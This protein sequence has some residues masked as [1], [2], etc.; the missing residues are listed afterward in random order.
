MTIE[1]I[2]AGRAAVDVMPQPF[3]GRKVG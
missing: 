2:A 1:E 3:P